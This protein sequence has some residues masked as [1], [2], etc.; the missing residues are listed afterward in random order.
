MKQESTIFR[1]P[2]AALVTAAAVNQQ[3]LLENKY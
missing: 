3:T 1:T 2:S